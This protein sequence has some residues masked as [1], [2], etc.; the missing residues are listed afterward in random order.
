MKNLA[1]H[2]VSQMED[3]YTTDYHYLTYTFSLKRLRE[4]TFRTW[5]EW[6]NNFHRKTS[7]ILLYLFIFFFRGGGRGGGQISWK[8]REAQQSLH[9]SVQ[10]CSSWSWIIGYERQLAKWSSSLKVLSRPLHG[11]WPAY[12]KHLQLA[13]LR[14]EPGETQNKSMRPS[15]SPTAPATRTAMVSLLIPHLKRTLSGDE[16]YECRYKLYSSPTLVWTVFFP[17]QPV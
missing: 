7:R 5:N 14:M 9:M 1:F 2:S 11:R 12:F 8:K 6:V 4:C 15:P 17:K 13:R 16:K 3:D 10:H